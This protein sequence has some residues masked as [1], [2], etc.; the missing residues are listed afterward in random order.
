[1]TRTDRY[2]LRRDAAAEERGRV[3]VSL[4]HQNSYN[5][6]CRIVRE[7]GWLGVYARTIG[8][9]PNL[10]GD[11]GGIGRNLPELEGESD[12][13]SDLALR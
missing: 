4:L 3:S 1:M 6:F 8:P 5:R 9:R 13:G 7:R 2:R 11:E 10:R 12:H